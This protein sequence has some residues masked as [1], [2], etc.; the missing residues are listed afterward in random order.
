MQIV[1]LLLA[2]FSFSSAESHALP[3][4]EWIKQQRLLLQKAKTLQQA[5]S[6]TKTSTVD[7]DGSAVTWRRLWTELQTT[8]QAQYIIPASALSLGITRQRSEDWSP[9][10]P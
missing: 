10:H 5:Q 9:L 7:R 4:V 1:I 3:A 2:L 8:Q 6:P